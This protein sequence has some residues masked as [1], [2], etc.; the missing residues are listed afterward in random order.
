MRTITIQQAIQA[1]NKTIIQVVEQ[2]IANLKEEFGLVHRYQNGSVVFVCTEG[3]AK[4]TKGRLD[5]STTGIR[6]TIEPNFF[7]WATRSNVVKSIREEL[8]NIIKGVA[9]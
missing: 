9:K 7:L 1:D 4:G 2:V 6:L 8:D 5:A 3:V